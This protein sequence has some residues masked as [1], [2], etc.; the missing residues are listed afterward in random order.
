LFWKEAWLKPLSGPDA[1]VDGGSAQETARSQGCSEQQVVAA[2][3]IGSSASGSDEP[4]Y[5]CQATLL[6]AASAPLKWWDY[7]QYLEDLTS[8]NASFGRLIAGGLYVL[9]HWLV[10]WTR[11]HSWRVSRALVRIYDRVQ[12]MRGGTPYPRRQ[13]TIPRGQPTPERNLDLAPGELVR[14]RPLEQILATLDQRNRNRGMFFDAE[15]V[16]FCGKTFRVR[17]RV[18]R[19]I[20][21]R[22]GRLLT[23][24]GQNVILENAWCQ[25]RYSDRRMLC[26]RAIYPFWR[27]TWLERLGE[28]SS[29]DAAEERRPHDSSGDAQ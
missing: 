13:G 14:V 27:E 24:K 11:R 7:R 22:T 6:P 12:K 20:D 19:I 26:P 10:N 25:A 17:S 9:Y 29:T 28:A 2:T 18:R 4:L 16:P 8:G 5:S 23:L 15:E 1:P 3:R 21:E